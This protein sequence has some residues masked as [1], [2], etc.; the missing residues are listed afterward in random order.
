[1]GTT[2]KRSLAVVFAVVFAGVLIGQARAGQKH[3]EQ[4]SDIEHPSGTT[5]AEKA[6]KSSSTKKG[7]TSPNTKRFD[8]YKN[9]KFR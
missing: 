1:M 4:P 3:N 2:V 7:S 5:A 8:P 6:D 9:F